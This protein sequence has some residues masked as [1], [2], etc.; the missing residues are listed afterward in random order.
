MIVFDTTHV[1][2]SVTTAVNR[3]FHSSTLFKVCFT[4]FF[5]ILAVA[6]QIWPEEPQWLLIFKG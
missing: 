6:L 1:D 2:C 4:Q 5:H 3:S